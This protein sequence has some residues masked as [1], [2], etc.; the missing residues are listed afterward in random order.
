MPKSL[1]G[2]FVIATR[3]LRDPNFFRSVVL[4]VEHGSEGAMGLVVNRPSSVTVA[5]ALEG[6]FELPETGD[7][8]YVGGPVEPAALFILHNSDDLDS[9]ERP[10]VPGVYIGSSGTIFEQVVQSAES[11]DSEMRFR[12]LSGCAGWSPGQLEGEVSRGDWLVRPATAALTFSPNPYEVWEAVCGLIS[13]DLG[14]IPSVR[15]NPEWN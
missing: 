9:S 8:V 3:R 10:V 14:L 1:R 13:S 5:R 12:V 11:G 2:Q 15:G 4:I 6:H 7:L